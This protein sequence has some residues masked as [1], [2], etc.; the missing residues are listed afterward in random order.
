MRMVLARWVVVGMVALAVFVQ[1][2][3]WGA[4]KI[5]SDGAL[6]EEWQP[7]FGWVYGLAFGAAQLAV[8]RW[9]AIDRGRL[10]LVRT[11]VIGGGLLVAVWVVGGRSGPLDVDGGVALV[12]GLGALVLGAGL[13]EG[14]L[15]PDT[16]R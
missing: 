10:W 1:L 2:G 5:R 16:A 14:R 4:T 12:S 11:W 7:Y 15:A 9:L 6:F 3:V 13:W 8:C